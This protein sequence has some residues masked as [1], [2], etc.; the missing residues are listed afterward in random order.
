MAFLD[1]SVRSVG[2]KELWTLQWHKGY[3]KAVRGPRPATSWAPTGPN[4]CV[5]TRTIDRSL[6]AIT[7][8]LAGS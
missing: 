7:C 5:A 1:W 2:L 8:G 4:G 3:I 6:S